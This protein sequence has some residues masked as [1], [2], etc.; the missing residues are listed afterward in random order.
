M[1][2]LGVGSTDLLSEPPPISGH[3]EAEWMGEQERVV[4]ILQLPGSIQSCMNSGGG[5]GLSYY[6]VN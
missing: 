2:V 3:E 5:A 1:Q 4:T 6:W